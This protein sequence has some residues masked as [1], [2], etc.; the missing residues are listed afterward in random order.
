MAD[1]TKDFQERDPA[2][3]IVLPSVIPFG[4]GFQQDTVPAGEV[5]LFL[6]KPESADII[7][8]TGDSDA[9][10]KPLTTQV[11]V[12]ARQQA[13]AD[14]LDKKP[15]TG[16]GASGQSSSQTQASMTGANQSAQPA[17][18]TTMQAQQ[19][20][21]NV[22][23]QGG[24]G[25][26]NPYENTPTVTDTPDT[27]DAVMSTAT[28]GQKKIHTLFQTLTGKDAIP[29]GEKWRWYLQHGFTGM[30]GGLHQELMN[31]INAETSAFG[32][33]GGKNTY[34]QELRAQEMKRKTLMQQWDKLLWEW[35]HGY[36]SGDEMSVRKFNAVA[37]KLRNAMVAEGISPDLIRDPS[38]NAG[39]FAQ[40][41]QKDIS[42]YRN[43]LDWL[44]GWMKTIEDN[45][46]ENPDWLNSNQATME[47]DKMSEY[48]I[49]NW[50]QSK[51]AIADAE[52]IRA[53]VEA[54][55][56]EDRQYYNGFMSS[57]F[58][59]N[60]FIQMESL[61][62]QGNQH[63][64]ELVSEVKR[65]INYDPKDASKVGGEIKGNVGDHI[66]QLIELIRADLAGNN[67]DLP[68]DLATAA[69]AYKT[70]KEAFDDYVMK[71]ANVDRKMV[72]DSA[73]DQ[74][75][76][77]KNSY[78]RLIQKGGLY[79]GW[80]YDGHIA[81]KDLSAKLSEWQKNDRTDAVIRNARLGTGTMAGDTTDP[82]GK[83]VV[84]GGGAGTTGTDKKQK[85]KPKALVGKNA[86]FDS[87]DG[88]WHY[89][90]GGKDTVYK[91]K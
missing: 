5:P 50:A 66:M 44:G 36:Y 90:K 9:L 26:K 16:A 30:H 67:L 40:G 39:G 82:T 28:D 77:L 1:L 68:I 70:S 78:D 20:T 65:L 80:G 63:A 76:I 46:A 21:V 6:T 18:D 74:L 34:G 35:N 4:F 32:G 58:R 47:F 72:W 7:K 59:G 11:A 60:A 83:I 52:K 29:Y 55:P 51:G 53:Q 54:M 71:N 88:E 12:N 57:F 75:N 56:E 24:N 23:V 22:N 45:I 17:A 87:D 42:N 14:K 37:N 3:N 85:P 15:K 69:N 84:R 64:K 27:S 25:E 79:Q 8:Q 49:L 10:A 33:T 13:P 73:A 43:K 62:Q 81:S 2:R 38:I 91:G 48:V 31:Q 41:F 89:M 61:A 19:P 86:W